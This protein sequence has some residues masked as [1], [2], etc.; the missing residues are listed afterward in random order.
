MLVLLKFIAYSIGLYLSS[1]TY[2]SGLYWE[3]TGTPI[4]Y[5]TGHFY[6]FFSV[7]PGKIRY[8]RIFGDN[9]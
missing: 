7:P 5:F 2:I 9:F 3:G 6:N 1:G 4:A 8:N